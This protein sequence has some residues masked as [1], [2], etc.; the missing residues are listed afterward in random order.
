MSNKNRLLVLEEI[1][2]THTSFDRK[3]PVRHLTINHSSATQAMKQVVKVT[4]SI[5]ISF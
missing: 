1:K 5:T 4:G 2:T 3:L